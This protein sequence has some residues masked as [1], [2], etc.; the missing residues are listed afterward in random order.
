MS[1]PEHTTLSFA[2]KVKSI[3]G[4]EYLEMCY[5][6]GTCTSKCMIQQKLDPDFNPRRLIHKAKVGIQ[7]EAFEDISTWLCTA[8]DLCYTACPQKVHISGVIFAIRSLAVQSGKKSPIKIAHI[9]EQT[10]VAC[11]L[12]VQVCP[13]EAIQIVD[14]KVLYRGFV[15]I[16]QVD[17]SRCMACGLCGAV[18]RSSS[19]G[20]EEDFADDFLINKL[21]QWLKPAAEVTL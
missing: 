12:C 2:D 7:V 18:C 6:C 13:Y 20:I 15:P 8:C 16:A 4:G 5:S 11:D 19:I 3:P 9:N 14:K 21:W 1:H 10:C 17:S